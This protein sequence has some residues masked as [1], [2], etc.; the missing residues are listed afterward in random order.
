ME[1]VLVSAKREGGTVTITVV[2]DSAGRFG[3]PASK[4]AAGRYS[5][6]IR[7]VGYDL[8]GPRALKSPPPAPPPST[9]SC[10]RP[11]TWRS[12]SPMRSGLQAFPEPT[13]K[14]KRCSIASAVTISIAS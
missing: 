12:N 9:S 5:L 2:S 8:E 7:A 6:A 4:L 1:G 14:R 11:R 3:F 13:R 10:G